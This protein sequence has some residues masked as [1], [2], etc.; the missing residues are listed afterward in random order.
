MED[1]RVSLDQ[2]NTH[3]EYNL[4]DLYNIYMDYDDNDENVQSP[5][6]AI[7]NKCENYEPSNMNHLLYDQNLALSMFCLNTQGLRAH[8]ESF[9]DLINTMHGSSIDEA[10]DII[11]VTELYGMSNGECNLDGY[12]HM[13][14]KTRDD[15]VC[16]RGGGCWY[17][18]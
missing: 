13:V 18:C 14:F 11:G 2:L 8:W 9:K 12:H 7:K 5:F 15:T 4:T 3:L 1:D 10:F 17:I 6:S 16:S